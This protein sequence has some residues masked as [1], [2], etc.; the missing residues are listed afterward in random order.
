MLSSAPKVMVVPHVKT[1]CRTQESR[2]RGK[3]QGQSELGMIVSHIY[4]IGVTLGKISAQP[5]L[6]IK[7]ILGE[8]WRGWANRK[9]CFADN[10]PGHN[11]VAIYPH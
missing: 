8:G 10:F 9:E 7:T 5:K 3:G 4:D 2:P 11:Y 1:V 6:K